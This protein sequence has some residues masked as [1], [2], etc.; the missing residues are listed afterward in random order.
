MIFLTVLLWSTKIF[1]H[2][3]FL[4]ETQPQNF[5]PEAIVIIKAI[6]TP[7][8]KTNIEVT[9]ILNPS[10]SPFFKS[11]GSLTCRSFRIQNKNIH[12]V[13]QQIQKYVRISF[14]NEIFFL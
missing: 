10:V 1:D 2:F 9:M 4:T 14:A 5:V 13:E 7:T 8:A 3:D 11:R 12:F 6:V